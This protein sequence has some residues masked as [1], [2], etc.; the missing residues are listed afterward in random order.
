MKIDELLTRLLCSSFLL[1]ELCYFKEEINGSGI[2]M[3]LPLWAYF[4][5]EK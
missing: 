4:A 1:F 2:C 5:R 3:L